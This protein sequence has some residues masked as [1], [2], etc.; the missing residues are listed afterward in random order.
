MAQDRVVKVSS[1]F[2]YE[3]KDT[4]MIYT[5][6]KRC[7]YNSYNILVD[8]VVVGS[9]AKAFNGNCGK[10]KIWYVHFFHRDI[11]Q[12]YG[13]DYMLGEKVCN[14]SYHEAQKALKFLMSKPEVQ[15]M[16]KAYALARK[17]ASLLYHI[18]GYS[19]GTG[20]SPINEAMLRAASR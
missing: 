7:Y 18:A 20:D 8:G 1:S 10:G 11:K 12:A 19:A 15:E 3:L 5:G 2:C 6:G 16:L 4:T 14:L 17:G 9:L 13:S